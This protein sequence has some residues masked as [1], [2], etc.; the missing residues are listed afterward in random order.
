MCSPRST[1]ANVVAFHRANFLSHQPGLGTGGLLGWCLTPLDNKLHP[2][3]CPLNKDAGEEADGV[4]LHV[5]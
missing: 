5:H 2:F 3:K 1:T 4:M